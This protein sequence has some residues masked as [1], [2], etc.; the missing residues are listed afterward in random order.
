ML[1]SPKRCLEVN[2]S[3]SNRLSIIILA[4]NDARYLKDA[5]LSAVGKGQVIVVDDS[6]SDNCMEVCDGLDIKYVRIEPCSIGHARNVG[7]S[8]VKTD[9]VTML[10]S[11]DK[12]L[13]IPE[14]AFEILSGDPDIGVVYGNYINFGSENWRMVPNKNIKWEH[15]LSNNQLYPT[16]IFKLV[17]WR[18]IKGYWENPDGIEDWDM[19]ARMY[20]RGW[21]FQ[22]I[23]HNFAEHRIHPD[24]SWLSHQRNG[25]EQMMRDLTLKHINED[26]NINASI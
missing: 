6:V 3:M 14:T 11:D 13:G 4:H 26:S 1:K 2:I 25:R 15:F 7:M 9:F 5:I 22:Y 20:K 24:S 10:D 16:S 12:L 8:L 19:W 18:S 21:K 23:D 17:A